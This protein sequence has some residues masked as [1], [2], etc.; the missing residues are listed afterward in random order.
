MKVNLDCKGILTIRKDNAV[1]F[2]E[3]AAD[4]QWRLSHNSAQGGVY[5]I[6]LAS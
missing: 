6:V 2:V 5:V 1:K 3:F 4:S